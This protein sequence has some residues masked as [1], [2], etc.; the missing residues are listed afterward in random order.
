[1]NGLQTRTTPGAAVEQIDTTSW[2]FTLPPGP[3]GQYRWAQ[4]DDYLHLPRSRFLWNPPFELR[5]RARVSAADLPGT[6]GFGLW[7]D[8]FN[9]SLGIGGTARRLP[10]MPNAAWFFYA[11]PPN[12][13]AFREGHPAEGLLAATFRSPL[14]PAWVLAL[15]AAALPLLAWPVTARLLRRAASRVIAEDAALV[16][17][18]P[19]DW[20]DYHLIWEAGQVRFAVD[21]TFVYETS[22]SPNGKLGLVIWIDNQ[23]AAFLADGRVRTGTLAY[24]REAWLEVDFR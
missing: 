8:P 1:M 3:A 9:L 5:L 14:W 4:L 11:S 19:T 16:P 21:G 22:T 7:N 6:W 18:D 15:G 20:H 23:Y 10:A 12:H 24:D 13:L 2:R 17:L